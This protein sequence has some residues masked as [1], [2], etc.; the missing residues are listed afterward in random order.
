M[1]NSASLRQQ[2]SFREFVD[3]RD[4]NREVREKR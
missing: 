4:V 1:D 2:L 3:L